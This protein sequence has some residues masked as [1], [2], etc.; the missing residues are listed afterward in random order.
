MWWRLEANPI[1]A[2]RRSPPFPILASQKFPFLLT[3]ILFYATSPRA[4]PILSKCPHHRCQP[5]DPAPPCAQAR[6]HPVP[7]PHNR[8]APPLDQLHALPH[9]HQTIGSSRRLY[10]V[11]LPGLPFTP[12]QHAKRSER[13][14]FDSPWLPNY[15]L[16]SSGL[17]RGPWMAHLNIHHPIADERLYARCATST[18]HSSLVVRE[19]LGFSVRVHIREPGMLHSPGLAVH[20][21]V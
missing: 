4:L 8:L 15:V 9:L 20:W 7:P 13:R 19:V 16:R 10:A 3:Y 17:R 1:K 18:P 12:A 11:A 21:H 6:S 14:A 5:H 2:P